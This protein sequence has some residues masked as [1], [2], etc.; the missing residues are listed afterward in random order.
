[1]LKNI[2]KIALRNLL[3]KNSHGLTNILG[4]AIGI[5]STLLI[6]MYCLNELS[7]DSMHP[8]ADKTYVL[9]Y[10]IEAPNFSG[11]FPGGPAGIDNYLRETFPSVTNN[12]GFELT[13]MP[14]TIKYKPM[15]KI[16]MTEEII[17]AEP[18]FNEM[19]Q[20]DV[21]KGS[22][23]KPLPQMNS[24]VLTETAA[25][26]LFGDKDPINE[27]V[28]LSH[29][30]V[31]DSTEISLLVSAVIKD[32]PANSY[33]R[34]NYIVNHQARRQFVD[35]PED[36]DRWDPN[37]NLFT[38]SFFVCENPDDIPLIKEDIQKKVDEA[39][40]TNNFPVEV[41]IVVRNIQEVHFDDAIDWSQSVKS[42]DKR[43]IYIFIAIAIMIL[44]VACINYINMTTARS[45]R[46]AKEIGLRKTFGSGKPYLMIQFMVE[47]FLTVLIAAI[48]ALVLV[49]ASLPYF[50][51]LTQKD[52][53]M[54][55]LFSM[56]ILSIF[57]AIILV[58]TFIAGFYPALY[59][60]GFQPAVVLKGN[61][62]QRSSTGLFR[63]I[64]TTLQFC[65]SIVLIVSSLVIVKQLNLMQDSKLNEAGEQVVSIRYGGFNGPVTVP[66]YQVYKNE[67]SKNPGIEQVTLANHL[68]RLDYF[69]PIRMD[70]KMPDFGDDVLQWKRLN[71]DY[72]F[73]ATFDME[74]ISGRLFQNGNTSDSSTYILNETAVE[75]LDMSPDEVIGK[76]LLQTRNMNFGGD[77][78]FA[79][80][81][82]GT[83]IGVVKDFPY[84]SGHN[85]IEPLVVTPRPHVN[86]RII[87]VRLTEG[88]FSSKLSYLEETWRKIYPEYGFDYW[89]ID[90]EFH[91]MYVQENQ[92][93]DMTKNFTFLA[94]LLTCF[95]V[96]GLSSFMAQQK[97]KEVGIRKVLGAN[98][99]Q[100]AYIM[101]ITFIRLILI[102]SV[103][104]IPVA[105]YLVY[106]YWLQDFA[107]QIGISLDVILI[108]TVVV[109][110]ITF[111]TMGWETYK[112]ATANPVESLKYE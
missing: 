87:H 88:D 98:T 112:A 45:V 51:D 90:D 65:I 109:L 100:I 57:S 84:E 13:G 105:T 53:V 50:N 16:V 68:P 106:Q 111:L 43:Y 19:Y 37:L 94:I 102:A 23:E 76:S 36:Y 14:T 4:L 17:W 33:L 61:L 26:A 20:M 1:M 44:A 97:I 52:F 46:R 67:L 21:V 59:M 29:M 22:Q 24:I 99:G 110:A 5:A 73:P 93:A 18:N 86:D 40:A 42:A 11:A 28:S 69:G 10:S 101:V 63:K 81:I 78:D 49:L 89:F 41:K 35:N 58:T 72:D 91:R 55:D 48:I 107:L 60:T 83:V 80:A 6:I 31:T 62:S 77:S 8:H 2:Y 47:S 82:V 66:K 39:I 30:F 56:Q 27:V 15:D 54:G 71:G 32:F 9:G 79:N 38:Q 103:I 104:A 12:V 92:I 85:A 70:Y 75:A 64:L 95:G 96:Y 3:R 34:P 7:H 25:N 108:P 74:L